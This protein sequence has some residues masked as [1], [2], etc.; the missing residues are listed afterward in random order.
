MRWKEAL[1]TFKYNTNSSD[2]IIIQN[3]QYK[4]L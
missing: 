2:K 1:L 4:L 3:S